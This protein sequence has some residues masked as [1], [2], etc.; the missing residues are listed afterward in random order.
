MTT[1]AE[2]GKSL[3]LLLQAY[4]NR[5]TEVFLATNPFPI[6]ALMTWH[7]GQCNVAWTRTIKLLR[8]LLGF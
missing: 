1:Y 3:S 2:A 7:P 6:L 8:S 5:S 4:G